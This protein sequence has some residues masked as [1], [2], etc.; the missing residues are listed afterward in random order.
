[1]ES[2]DIVTDQECS[3][4]AA[5]RL[6][7]TPSNDFIE[8]LTA[9]EKSKLSAV[10]RELERLN[11]V[12]FRRRKEEQAKKDRIKNEAKI[13]KRRLICSDD[14]VPSQYTPLECRPFYLPHTKLKRLNHVKFRRRKEEQA[15]KDRIKNEAKISKRR[16][17]RSD[18]PVPSQ[19]TPLERR[20]FYLPHTELK[21]SID[22]L[23]ALRYIRSLLLDP[24]PALVIDCQFLDY[25]SPRGLNL[26]LLQLKYLFSENRVRL[27]PWP[28]YLCNFHSQNKIISEQCKLHLQ[29]FDSN[30]FVAAQFF[31]CGFTDL[32]PDIDIV[33]L[34]PHADS[35]LEKVEGN[36]VF[37]LGG[38]VDRTN[39][40]RLP[41]CAS[42]LAAN[43][44]HV[45]ARKLPLD[46]YIKSAFFNCLV[47]YLLNILSE[48]HIT[49]LCSKMIG[50]ENISLLQT[51]R[52]QKHGI[53][54]STRFYA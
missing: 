26:T 43:N 29:M 46:K 11:H 42:L 44:A 21:R 16:L 24:Q 33:Y 39:E 32:F 7:S 45:V 19:Y 13:S 51:T 2:E 54:K 8:S 38:I 1:M 47:L 25:L 10:V 41:K 17:I 15:K 53:K 5:P 4:A 22:E 3:L 20:P 48:A 52:P 34:S 6:N 18:D 30:R 36:E 37:V 31:S 12:K 50:Q 28:I 23:Q 14:P 40:P 35:E 27:Q 49:D 9:E